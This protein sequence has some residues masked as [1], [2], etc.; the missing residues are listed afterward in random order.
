MSEKEVA[1]D[2]VAKCADAE[3]LEVS[4][5]STVRHELIQSQNN[6][7]DPEFQRRERALVWKQD[8]HI[9]P[10]SAFIY[11]LCYL[12]RSNIGMV[13]ILVTDQALMK[14]RQC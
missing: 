3:A 13:I 11:L 5:R 8:L 10:L 7:S 12:D 1:P 14:H 9:I 2:G 4:S 6:R